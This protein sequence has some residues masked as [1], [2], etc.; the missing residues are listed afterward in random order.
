MYVLVTSQDFSTPKLNRVLNPNGPRL[1][2]GFLSTRML[3]RP[4]QAR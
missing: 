4:R 3:L 2:G 1:T